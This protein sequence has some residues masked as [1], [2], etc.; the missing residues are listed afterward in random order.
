MDEKTKNELR[1]RTA[2]LAQLGMGEQCVRRINEDGCAAIRCH[3]YSNIAP[4]DA[5]E[6]KAVRAALEILD[7]THPDAIGYYLFFYHDENAEED[8]YTDEMSVLYI[9]PDEERW[10]ATKQA[11]RGGAVPY[12]SVKFDNEN[13]AY[14][15]GDPMECTGSVTRWASGVGDVLEINLEN[16]N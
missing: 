10:D 4:M 16:E 2:I 12:L 15:D 11:M 5:D 13:L 8:G 1:D 7:K 14:G 3:D 9:E 6:D